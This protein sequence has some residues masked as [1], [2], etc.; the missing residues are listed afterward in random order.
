M[1]TAKAITSPR[2]S[3]G[4]SYTPSPQDPRRATPAS[5]LQA[6]VL[7]GHVRVG[8]EDNLYLYIEQ[9][10]LSPGSAPRVRRAVE[11]I[12]AVGEQPASVAEARKILGLA[13]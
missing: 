11:I 13:C 5:T 12:R 6:V 1:K 2:P 10:R 8:L 7:E 9:G 3:P 4:A